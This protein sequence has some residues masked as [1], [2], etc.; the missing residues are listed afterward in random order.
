MRRARTK[1][2]SVENSKK[3]MPLLEASDK[4]RAA[5]K[6][7]EEQ[8]DKLIEVKGELETKQADLQ[9]M[10][11]QE[12]VPEAN[13]S[14]MQI[15]IEGHQQHVGDLRRMFYETKSWVKSA[16]RNLI[17]VIGTLSP[18]E[19]KKFKKQKSIPTAAI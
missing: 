18:A 8:R 17:Y 1:V 12:D 6:Q 14:E 9:H 15:E 4:V 7:Y 19:I 10:Q 13:I 3:Y 2:M 5:N 16:K 11:S